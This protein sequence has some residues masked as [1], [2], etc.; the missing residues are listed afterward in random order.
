MKAFCEFME[1]LVKVDKV[2][3]VE[4]G[5]E[6]AIMSDPHMGKAVVVELYDD[7]SKALGHEYFGTGPG[8]LG[9]L[10]EDELGIRERWDDG[11]VEELVFSVEEHAYKMRDE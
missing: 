9:Q 3:K 6:V 1:R 11:F 8:F 2:D 7:I 10:S 5:Q 4:V